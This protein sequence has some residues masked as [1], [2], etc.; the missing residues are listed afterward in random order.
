MK[1]PE[2][3]VGKNG[4]VS[5]DAKAF[6][7]QPSVQKRLKAMQKMNIVGMKLDGAHLRPQKPRQRNGKSG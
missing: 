4:G 1:K 2:I 6:F 3:Y 7:A 5:V